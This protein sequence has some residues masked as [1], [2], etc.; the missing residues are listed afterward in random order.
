MKKKHYIFIFFILSLLFSSLILSCKSKT[1]EKT[2]QRP[3]VNN[4]TVMK[5]IPSI[6]DEVFETTGTVRAYR[7]SQVASRVMGTVT[8]L[9]VQEGDLVSR[10]Q[11]LLTIDGR[12]TAER[13]Q[14][15]VMALESA[16]QNKLLQEVTWQRYKNLF[17]ERAISRQEMDQ[18]DTQK[19]VAEAD[20]Q[21]AKA[22]ANEARTYQ[23]F[24]RV[25]APVSGRISHKYIDTGSMANP[26]MPLIAIEE[27]GNFYVEAAIDER[28]RDKVKQGMMVELIL[29]NPLNV[30]HGTIQHVL[31]PIDSLSR[32]FIIKV[33]FPHEHSRS[34]LFVRVK[35]PVGKK[36]VILVPQKALVHKGQLTGVYAV[37]NQGIITY[38]LVRT[39]MVYAND[40]EIISGLTSNDR[41]ITEGIER[42]IDGGIIA[43]GTPQ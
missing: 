34:G 13:L 4:V 1:P 9:H 20:Y 22:A 26:G 7:T 6:V 5:V 39:G 25:T 11:L 42:A 43:G 19:K 21:R 36:E 18:I 12:D 41:L 16:R 14:S 17:D 27:S 29:D 8:S 40:M 35:I 33:S 2:S 23:S 10:G 28:L 31:P 24:T 38:R 15:A 30:Q 32:S 37:D 3:A